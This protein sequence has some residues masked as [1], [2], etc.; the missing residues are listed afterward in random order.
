MRISPLVKDQKTGVDTVRHRGVPEDAGQCHIDGVG[1]T[2]KVVTG[3]K[4]GD[5]GVATQA[6]RGR[7]TCNAGANDGYALRGKRG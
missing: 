2:P 7:Q 5:V 3:F 4:Q 1:M 6:V